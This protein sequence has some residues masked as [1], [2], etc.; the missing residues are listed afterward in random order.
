[1]RT[2]GTTLCVASPGS[3]PNTS[4]VQVCR[5]VDGAPVWFQDEWTRVDGK[6]I[7]SPGSRIWTSPST[8]TLTTTGT[9]ASTSA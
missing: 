1:M 7:E 9:S 6:W 3:S 2:A 8:S 4:I 5:M